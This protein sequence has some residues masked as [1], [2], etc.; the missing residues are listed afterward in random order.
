VNKTF[1]LWERIDAEA[2]QLFV[3]INLADRECAEV[4][5]AT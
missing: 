4:D 1:S 3:V 5:S 2:D